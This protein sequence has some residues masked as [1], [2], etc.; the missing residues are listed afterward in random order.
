VKNNIVYGVHANNYAIVAN[1]SYNGAT[2]IVI[3]N[4]IW[5]APNNANWYYWNNA[6]GANIATWNALTEVGT[7]LNANPLLTATYSLGAGSPATDKAIPVFTAAQ[8]LANGD[9]AGN[10][11]VYGAGPDIGAFEKKKFIFDEDDMLPKKC[12]TTNAA[13]YVQP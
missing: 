3:T 1:A 9:F 4:N 11:Y 13:C 2:D 8:W 5:Y 10:H 6:A 12:K 7:D